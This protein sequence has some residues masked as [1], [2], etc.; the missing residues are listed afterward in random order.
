MISDYTAIT[1]IFTHVMEQTSKVNKSRELLPFF[2]EDQIKYIR[3][4]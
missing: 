3:W 2:E 4:R 1:R